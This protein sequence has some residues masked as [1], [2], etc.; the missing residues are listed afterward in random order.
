MNTKSELSRLRRAIVAER[1]RKR[2]QLGNLRSRFRFQTNKA[3]YGDRF[4]LD[5]DYTDARFLMERAD[6]IEKLL[7]LDKHDY[8]WNVKAES[9]INKLREAQS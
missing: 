4:S 1:L 6:A 8:N 2:R 9:I 3:I 7:K 5:L